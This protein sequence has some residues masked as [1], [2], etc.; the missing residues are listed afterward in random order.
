MNCIKKN[1]QDITSRYL[2]V[3]SKS[4]ISPFLISSI[5]GELG[6]TFMFYIGSQFDEDINEEFYSAK[7]INNVSTRSI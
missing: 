6:K 4:S 5:L 2:L 3:I 1:I 7:I